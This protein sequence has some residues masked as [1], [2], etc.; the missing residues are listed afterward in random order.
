VVPVKKYVRAIRNQPPQTQA[1][2]QPKVY[3]DEI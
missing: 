2:K 1:A 3:K